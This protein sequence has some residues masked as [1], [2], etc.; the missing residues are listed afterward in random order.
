MSDA[1]TLGSLFDGSGGFP[2]AALNVGIRPV[3]AS[4][5]EPF[6]ILVTRTRLPS[7]QHLGDVSLIDGAEITPVDI[8]TFGSPCQDLSVAGRQQ[9]LG[10]ARSGLFFEAVRII[11]QM[12]EATHGR[13]PRYAIWENVPGAFSSNHGH[14]FAAVLT[15]LLNIKQGKEGQAG[16]VDV[17]VPPAGWADAGTILGGGCSVA[18]RVLDAQYF[19]LAQRRRRI[20][21]ICDFASQRAPEILF[22]PPSSP[23]DPQP[24][25]QEEQN[26]AP[27]LTGSTPRSGEGVTAIAVEHHPQ[28]SRIK[29]KTDGVVQTLTARMGNSPTNVPIL[30]E[31]TDSECSQRVFGL[32]SIHESRPTGG[33]YGY[34]A[35]VSKTLDLR[36]GEPCCNQGGMVVLEPV[37]AASKADFFT[38][39]TENQ[40]GALLAS[41]YTAPPVVAGVKYRPRRL[42]PTECARLQGF[43]DSWCEGL[44]VTDP[45]EEELTFWEQVWIH[46]NGLRGVKPRTR[47][48]IVKWLASPGGDR[49]EYKLWGNGIALP[50][51]EY[52]LRRLSKANK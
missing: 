37:Y 32:N 52:V 6:P 3:W 23:R 42:T 49:A 45:S 20:Y 14:D 51:A 22:E 12:R 48:Q 47:N 26:H 4:E 19:G 34:E 1:L 46:W 21:L 25:G 13:Y 7:V 30:L 28:D 40:A 27:T 36:G 38:R 9:G 44:E 24:G 29:V 2:L 5:V 43:P 50:V 18:W 39:A 11:R 10:G 33:S 17:P 35:V 8:V 31:A 15:S 41:D 16:A